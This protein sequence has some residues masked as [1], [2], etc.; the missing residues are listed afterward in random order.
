MATE[1]PD[2]IETEDQLDA[3]LTKPD[4]VVLE[5]VRELESPLV[6]VGAGGKMGPTL[7]VLAKRAADAIG[8]DLQVIAASRFRNPAA[9]EWLERQG[10]ETRCTDLLSRDD[11]A[12]LPDTSNLLYLVG[13]KFG[14]SVDPVPTWVTNTIAP[15]HVSERYRGCKVVAL[16]TGN[17][18]PN[19]PIATGGCSED[20]ALTPLGEYANAAVAR[21]VVSALFPHGFTG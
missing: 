18:Y 12:K 7:A 8:K 17:V 9:H 21:T 11:V 20:Q 19:V 1:L 14:T 3:I 13:M 2:L 15:M 5:S 6:V 4:S 10:I 16:S